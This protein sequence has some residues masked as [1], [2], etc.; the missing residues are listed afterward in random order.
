MARERRRNVL[1]IVIVIVV[2]DDNRVRVCRWDG[3]VAVRATAFG[4]SWGGGPSTQR[5]PGVGRR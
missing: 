3:A 5:R 1:C 2:I 4:T